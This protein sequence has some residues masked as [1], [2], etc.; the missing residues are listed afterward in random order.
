MD[1]NTHSTEGLGGQGI[2][3]A[4]RWA[5]LVAAAQELAAE[6]LD[7]LSDA[8]LAEDVVELRRLVDR[9]EGQWLRRLAVVDARGVAG[10]DQDQ[11][12]PPPPAGCV[13]GY[14]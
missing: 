9:L 14:G 11:P 3:L 7:G 4:E 12:A 6:D 10:A 2:G 8:A 1:S 13:I 5:S